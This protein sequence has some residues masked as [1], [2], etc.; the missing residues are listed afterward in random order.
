M[1]GYIA[2]GVV[3]EVKNLGIVSMSTEEDLQLCLS[4]S[5]QYHSMLNRCCTAAIIRAR[6]LEWG[7]RSLRV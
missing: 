2:E 4:L 6:G 1:T 5:M 3:L 7:R